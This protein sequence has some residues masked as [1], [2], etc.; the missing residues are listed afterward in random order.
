MPPFCAPAAYCGSLHRTDNHQPPAS[1]RARHA[2]P[3]DHQPGTES[4]P[5]SARAHAAGSPPRTRARRR[6]ASFGVAPRCH[7]AAPTIPMAR[8]S[9]PAPPTV[10][11]HCRPHAGTGTGGTAR[12]GI[13]GARRYRHASRH[14][15]GGALRPRRRHP[16]LGPGGAD[17][18]GRP[19]RHPAGSTDAGSAGRSG[20]SLTAVILHVDPAAQDCV[21]RFRRPSRLVGVGGGSRRSSSAR[22]ALA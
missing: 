20:W 8:C 9:S 6:H 3:Q 18:P 11:L 15:A 13:V 10:M 5:I 16:G 17:Q 21:G 7:A 19:L 2:A 14:D 22:M 4:C 12:G 1:S